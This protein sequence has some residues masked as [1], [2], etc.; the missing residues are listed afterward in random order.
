MEVWSSNWHCKGLYIVL[1]LKTEE[2]DLKFCNTLSRSDESS[3]QHEVEQNELA[4]SLTTFIQEAEKRKKRIEV[5]K[6]RFCETKSHNALGKL[7]GN[8]YS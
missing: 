5:R 7:L 4:N 1:V 3:Y 2:V 6:K 8:T